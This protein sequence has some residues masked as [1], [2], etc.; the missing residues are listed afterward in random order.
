MSL[1]RADGISV[2]F[3]G[4]TQVKRRMLSDLRSALD[5]GRIKMPATGFWSEVRKQLRKYKLADR[6]LEQD[7]VMCLAIVVKLLRQSPVQVRQTPTKLDMTQGWVPD[8]EERVN[9]GINSRSLRSKQ[10]QRRILA[11]ALTAA[12]E[13]E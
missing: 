6:K 4:V 12:R 9:D 10:R 8:E 7:L 2:E 5:E 13:G 3:G 1:L 11:R